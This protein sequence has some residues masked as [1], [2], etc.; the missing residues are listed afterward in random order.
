M[1]ERAQSP[2]GRLVRLHRERLGLTQQA[3]ADQLNAHPEAEGRFSVRTIQEWERTYPPGAKWRS[4]HPA[5]LRTLA[6]VLGIS[7]DSAAW[8][9]L[10]QAARQRQQS[11][12]SSQPAPV[13]GPVYA[14][15][16]AVVSGED[17]GF[18]SAGRESHLA[19]LRDAID[20]ATGGI[21]AV[22]FVEA[23]LGSGKSWLAARAVRDALNGHPDLVALWG[24]SPLLGDPGHAI[25]QILLQISGAQDVIDQRYLPFDTNRFHRRER[26]EQGIETLIANRE[27]IVDRF[28]PLSRLNEL[29]TDDALPETTRTRLQ[30]VV[31]AGYPGPGTA[32]PSELIAR[33][34]VDYGQRPLVIVLDDMQWANT[35]TAAALHHL[36][37]S[38]AGTRL[39]VAV[40]GIFRPSEMHDPQT[41][42]PTAM[43]RVVQEAGRHL[44]VARIDLSEAVGGITGRAFVDA[45]VAMH[46]AD[47]P[48]D[49]AETLFHTTAGLPLLVSRMLRWYRE[50]GA[51]EERADGTG[52]KWR[53]QPRHLP[54]DVSAIMQGLLDRIPPD[55]QPILDLAAIQGSDFSVDV[56][57][58]T[59]KLPTPELIRLLDS[60]LVRRHHLVTPGDDLV[61][62]GVR[63]HTYSFVHALFRDEIYNRLSPFE[64]THHHLETAVALAGLWGEGPH[65]GCARIALHYELAG[66][67]VQAGAWMMHWGDY[68]LERQHFGPAREAY[69]AVQAFDLRQRAPRLTA[70][71]HVGLGN[72]ARGEGLNEEGRRHFAL[73][74]EIAKREHLPQVQANA[75]TSEAMLDF[76]AGRMRRGAELLVTAIHLQ[77][78]VG[79]TSEAARSLTLLSHTL[80]GTGQH[81]EAATRAR[82]AIDLARELR[83]DYLESGALIALGN[84]W[85]DI[86]LYNEAVATYHECLDVCE[87]QNITHR[88][89]ISW[90]NI[91]LCAFETERWGQGREALSQ[92]FANAEQINPRLMGAAHFNLAVI[93]EL[94][95]SLDEAAT[96]YGRSLEIREEIRQFALQI[97]SRAGL[98]RLAIAAN[99]A[100]T[101]EAHTAFI[102]GYLQER[103][104]EGIEHPGRL[105]VTLVDAHGFLGQPTEQRQVLDQGLAMLDTRAAMLPDAAHRRAYLTKVPSHRALRA[106]ADALERKPAPATS[107]RQGVTRTG[108]KSQ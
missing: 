29:S 55:L 3:L 89:A 87:R 96:H 50:E 51:L 61:I 30:E 105:F 93:A 25:R 94:T 10:Q 103:G 39:P 41:G 67:L 63:S 17:R 100:P 36:L 84:C 38:L 21:P 65:E 75:L 106:R 47:A 9:D 8:T 102:E 78:E 14:A 2:F 66:D 79:D 68:W 82:E 4:P 26:L 81:G 53:R 20:Q 32:G 71:S 91:S 37:L 19:R 72:C 95:G 28:L 85:L 24:D 16:D 42:L 23:E 90:L 97:D 54:S 49:L 98:A 86:G 99:D 34:L 60:Q 58:R 43:G 18:I 44:P 40:I 5:N 69:E 62:A 45:F 88:A 73:A 27:G 48:P 74:Q 104:L 57:Q 6:R 77:Q 31:A 33:I 56:L 12:A 64:R 15:A 101:V 108:A 92:V 1:A 52:F 46:V 83:K 107:L 7:F 13:T 35:G 80:H 59:L 70:Q 11:P 22:A 76:D